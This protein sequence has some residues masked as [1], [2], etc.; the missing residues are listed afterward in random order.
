MIDKVIWASA[1]R[2]FIGTT[3][4]AAIIIAALAPAGA[5]TV[6]KGKQ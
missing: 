2:G 5:Q 4:A 6:D 3:A 1:L